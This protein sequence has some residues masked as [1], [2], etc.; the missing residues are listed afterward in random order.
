MH[1]TKWDAAFRAP[2]NGSREKQKSKYK[3]E[4]QGNNENKKMGI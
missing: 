3:R 1:Q 2:A 4:K